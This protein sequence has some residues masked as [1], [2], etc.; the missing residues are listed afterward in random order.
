MRT[1]DGLVFVAAPRFIEEIRQAPDD[2]LSAMTAS[3]EVLQVKYTLH[4]VLAHSW[5]EFDTIR[6]DLTRS[7]GKRPPIVN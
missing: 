1:P 6:T 3:N 5:Y 7:L 4:P 2:T